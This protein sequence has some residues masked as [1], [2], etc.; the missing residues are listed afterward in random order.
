MQIS[1]YQLHGKDHDQN[2]ADPDRV[3]CGCLG[4]P[5]TSVAVEV[6]CLPP[7]GSGIWIQGRTGGWR[8]LRVERYTFG[9]PS[10]SGRVTAWA[11]YDAEE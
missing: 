5:G 3:R 11:S 4:D 7:V 2:R 1:V 8:Q 6:P 10:D 9:D